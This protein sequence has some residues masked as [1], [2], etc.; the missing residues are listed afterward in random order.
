MKSLKVGGLL[1]IQT[2]QA[3]PL[4]AYP[5]DYFR[6]S[7][8]AMSGLFGTRM[9]FRVDATA[10]EFSARIY[11]RREGAVRRSPAHLNVLLHG[12][13]IAPTPDTYVF[14]LDH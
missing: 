13:K 6:F 8:E 2:H 1:F 3:F 10:Y 5:Y 4:H 7:R 11:S 12:E 14:E 9:G